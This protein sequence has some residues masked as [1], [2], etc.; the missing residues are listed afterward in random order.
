[1]LWVLIVF[2]IWLVG[3]TYIYTC[4]IKGFCQR[5]NKEIVK[6]NIV[7]NNDKNVIR[8]RVV[9]KEVPVKTTK[10]I[11]KV[12]KKTIKC[13]TYLNSYIKLN[14]KNN[15]PSEVRKLEEF[16]N[17]YYN[18]NLEVNGVYESQDAEALKKFQ[19][20]QNLDQDG[21]LGPKTLEVLNAY[22]CIQNQNK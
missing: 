10:K 5:Q 18:A 3:S 22:Y 9:K 17:K 4:N 6:S 7:E 15:F 16:L 21:V 19:K 13:L 2:G 1:M 12:E 20:E 14:S 11:V 8:E